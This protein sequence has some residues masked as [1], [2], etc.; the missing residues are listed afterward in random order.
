MI[1]EIFG[2][3]LP[4]QTF[5]DPAEVLSQIQAGRK[6]LAM[7]IYSDDEAF[8]TTML[9]G[10]SSGG[11]TVN[12]FASHVAEYRIPFGGVNNSGR[13]RY[14]GIHGFRD[15]S[16]PRSGCPGDQSDRR[17]QR[18]VSPAR[19]PSTEYAWL[20]EAAGPE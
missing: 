4:V 13:G 16:N 12:G 5:A 10:T 3:V 15:F 11:V 9:A 7:Y 20:G 6:P 19:G 14:H 18:L 2:P 17:C 1:Q 8:V